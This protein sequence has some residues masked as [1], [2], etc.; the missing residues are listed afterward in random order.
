MVCINC[1]RLAHGFTFQHT[2]VK[3]RACTQCDQHCRWDRHW[4]RRAASGDPA[5]LLAV[6][7]WEGRR[8]PWLPAY[9]TAQR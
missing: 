3:S 2:F 8:T 7:T 1:G 5:P 9:R 6:L 4:T